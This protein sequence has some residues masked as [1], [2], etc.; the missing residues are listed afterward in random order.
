M[1]TPTKLLPDLSGR[2]VIIDHHVLLRHPQQGEGD[3]QL[4]FV[5]R[6]TNLVNS[7]IERFS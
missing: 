4:L 6:T 5:P 7:L 2:E 3:L 1:F